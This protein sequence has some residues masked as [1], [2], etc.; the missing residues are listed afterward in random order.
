MQKTR[1]GAQRDL[2]RRLRGFPQSAVSS[3]MP[4]STSPA[5][6]V[7]CGRSG[8]P[9]SLM[10]SWVGSFLF[11]LCVYNV[12]VFLSWVGSFSTARE[13]ENRTAEIGV[14]VG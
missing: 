11:I 5:A 7:N 6:S 3:S 1:G 4:S 14:L 12:I 9:Y 8:S 10:V 13:T 2:P